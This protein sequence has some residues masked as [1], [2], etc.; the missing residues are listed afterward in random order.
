MIRNGLGPSGEPKLSLPNGTSG[1]WRHTC[2][3]RRFANCRW[4]G[5]PGAWKQSRSDRPRLGDVGNQNVRF[6]ESLDPFPPAAFP[7]SRAGEATLSWFDTARVVPP[8]RA[9]LEEEESNDDPNAQICALA[10]T[11]RDAIMSQR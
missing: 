6:H 1:M 8:C 11:E 5:T 7:V 9:P 4:Y 3:T 2:W 10:F